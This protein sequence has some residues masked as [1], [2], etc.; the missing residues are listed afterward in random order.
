MHIQ[1]NVH[2]IIKPVNLFKTILFL[3]LSIA[4]NALKKLLEHTESETMIKYM[5]QNNGW[6]LLEKEDTCP[7]GCLHLAR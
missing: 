5:E 7:H 6:P 3:I 4:I 2:S 1:L